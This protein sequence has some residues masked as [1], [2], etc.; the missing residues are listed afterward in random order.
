MW[1]HISL[2]DSCRLRTVAIPAL[3]SCRCLVD[4]DALLFDLDEDFCVRTRAR[5]SQTPAKTWA[6]MR[7]GSHNANTGPAIL[8][9]TA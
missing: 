5:S 1:H 3:P 4:C 8:L 6:K 2:V 9:T 7:H